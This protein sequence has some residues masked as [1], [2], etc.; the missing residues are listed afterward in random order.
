MLLQINPLIKERQS[1]L[2]SAIKSNDAQDTISI[3]DELA[4]CLVSG[5]YHFVPY[6][7]E[8]SDSSIVKNLKIWA[9]KKALKEKTRLI[10]SH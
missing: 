7:N 1:R 10:V 2:D 5:Q 6:K 8:N 9:N 4:G 3:M